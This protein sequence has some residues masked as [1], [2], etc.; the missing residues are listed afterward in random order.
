MMSTAKKLFSDKTSQ[1]IFDISDADY[2]KF[3]AISNSGLNEMAKSPA[4]FQAWLRAPKEP[5]AAM[6][7]GTIVHSA[8]L[9]PKKFY[10][11]TVSCPEKQILK[12]DEFKKVEAMIEEVYSHP[13][14]SDLLKVGQSEQS[15][16]W[17]DPA[18]GAQ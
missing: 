10:A 13:T 4:H 14:A 7:F 8:I 2:R 12:F 18:T 3:V 1:G 6:R 5:T 16:I 15:M 17:V 9:E 11:S